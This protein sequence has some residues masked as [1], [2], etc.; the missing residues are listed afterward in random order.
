[1]VDDTASEP[2]SQP[3]ER[4]A[5]L[6]VGLFLA[7][8]VMVWLVVVS[9]SYAASMI[10]FLGDSGYFLA[11]GSLC[12]TVPVVSGIDR[13]VPF[14]LAAI[15]LGAIFL[16]V[17]KSQRFYHYVRVASLLSIIYG[18]VNI[19][20]GPFTFRVGPASVDPSSLRCGRWP[21]DITQSSDLT[22]MQIDWL[23]MPIS[24]FGTS[25]LA[26]SLGIFVYVRVSKRVARVYR[27]G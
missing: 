23:N 17:T 11:Y 25:L 15:W 6:S 5:G 18:A 26:L 24:V 8:A 19:A 1:M 9:V 4:K 13:F 22:V 12:G 7:F 10:T 27:N 2:A 16:G 20:L 3:I 21:R 14:L